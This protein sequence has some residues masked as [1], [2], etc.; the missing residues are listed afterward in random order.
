[1]GDK[2][3]IVSSGC[4]FIVLGVISLA[5]FFIFGM[6]ELINRVFLSMGLAMLVLSLLVKEKDEEGSHNSKV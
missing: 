4:L 1:M 6:H 3:A 2:E 5:L